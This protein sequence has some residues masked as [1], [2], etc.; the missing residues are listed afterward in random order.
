M[1]HDLDRV[2]KALA[3]GHR[4]RLLDRLRARPGQTLQE[5]CAGLPMSRQAVAKHLALLA[6]AHLVVKVRHGREQ[7]HYLNPVPLHAVCERW[8]GKF[9]IPHLQALSALKRR[10]EDR[11]H[12]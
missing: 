4:R 5:L 11:P 7:W 1:A 2:F 12:E 9:E 8:I 3:D 10:L 6:R